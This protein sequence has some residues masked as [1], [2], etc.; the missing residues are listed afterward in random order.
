MDQ[1]T[2][3]GSGGGGASYTQPNERDYTEQILGGMPRLSADS[4]SVDDI[5]GQIT[6]KL[7]TLSTGASDEDL[8]EAFISVLDV[9]AS[10]AT[11]FLESAA[12]KLDA[13][14][15]IFGKHEWRLSKHGQ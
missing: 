10:M 1:G 9:E 11:F 8:L 15:A 5:L 14:V 2:G 6:S 12:W 4:L 7:D 3:K 13:A